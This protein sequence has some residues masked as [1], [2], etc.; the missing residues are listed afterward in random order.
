MV[1]AIVGVALRYP[2]LE[3]STVGVE[4]T[5]QI[6]SLINTA[7]VS[8]QILG[9][10]LELPRI[11]EDPID[12]IVW[13]NEIQYSDYCTNNLVAAFGRSL[14]L[15]IMAEFKRHGM[16][17]TDWIMGRSTR[18]FWDNRRAAEILKPLI[19]HQILRLAIVATMR[20]KQYEI[21]HMLDYVYL[22]TQAEDYEISDVTEVSLRLFRKWKIRGREKLSPATELFL[23][24][25]SLCRSVYRTQESW[26]A[27]GQETI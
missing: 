3:H 14:D 22:L 8:Y 15:D 24:S 6:A 26:R 9:S 19:R 11:T 7:F 25:G 20:L 13:D 21:G 17:T 27:Q 10:K 23:V 12:R 5:E 16:C 1:R 18:I 2:R 4:K